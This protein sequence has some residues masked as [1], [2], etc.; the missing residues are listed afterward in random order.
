MYTKV[1]LSIP[2]FAA[3][4]GC[5]QEDVLWPEG[6]GSLASEKAPPPRIRLRVRPVRGMVEDIVTAGEAHDLAAFRLCST[7]EPLI[8]SDF[9]LGVYESALCGSVIEY[10][11][12]DGFR[13]LQ[14]SDVYT[15][16]GEIPYTGMSLSV[17]RCGRRSAVMIVKG[18]ISEIGP[19]YASPEV[20]VQVSWTDLSAQATGLFSGNVYDHRAMT[21]EV[22]GPVMITHQ[23]EP[24]FTHTSLTT[25]TLV[26]GTLTDVFKFSVECYYSGDLEMEEFFFDITTTDSGGTGWNTCGT[27]DDYTQYKIYK[28]GTNIT[29]RFSASDWAF[30]NED[31]I[32]CS[33]VPGDP[34]AYM[35]LTNFTDVISAGESVAYTLRYTIP[36]PMTATVG[37]ELTYGITDVLWGYNGSAPAVIDY[38]DSTLID[39]LPMTG[40]TWNF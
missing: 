34:V 10:S 23:T 36:Y 5:A 20:G 7:G 19:G 12:Y 2:L 11:I 9:T 30:Y 27:F 13:N 6:Q 3:L 40:D 14:G 26:P 18:E 24:T 21:D 15:C 31:G 17:P 32:E 16:T 29:S 25:S 4:V 37:D 8:L 35:E 28:N 33:K 39:G 22:S 38:F 1:L